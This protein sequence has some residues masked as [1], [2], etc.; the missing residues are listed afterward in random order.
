MRGQPHCWIGARKT[1]RTLHWLVVRGERGQ[2]PFSTH[3]HYG[4]TYARSV[5]S[6]AFFSQ[7]KNDIT[8][9]LGL[10][11]P[12][13]PLDDGTTNVAVVDRF[14]C[15]RAPGSR[16][17][18]G[19]GWH[20]RIGMPIAM[21]DRIKTA[22]AVAAPVPF[23]RSWCGQ[24][25]RGA[26]AGDPGMIHL[27]TARWRTQIAPDSLYLILLKLLHYYIFDFLLMFVWL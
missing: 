26:R 20:C 4:T 10:G 16:T 2:I 27:R 24:V 21:Q 25:C 13:E 8:I 22:A 9:W 3:W 12:A 5:C 19:A 6:L 1:K 18:C 14:A 17:R 15:S 23:Q 7:K 11:S